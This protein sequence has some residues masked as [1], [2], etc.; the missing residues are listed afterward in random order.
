MSEW[1]PITEREPDT[2][3]HVLVTLK[4]KDNDYE[5]VEMDYGTAKYAAERLNLRRAKIEIN[6]IVA[7]MPLPQPYK[8]AENNGSGL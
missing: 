2:A 5:V 3:D 1:I 6:A 4:W 8:E 7:W